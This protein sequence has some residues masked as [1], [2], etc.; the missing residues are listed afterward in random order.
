MKNH[1]NEQYLVNENSGLLKDAIMK[2]EVNRS[3]IVFTI[4][5]NNRLTGVITEG[6]VSRAL[7]GNLTV[8]AS[9]NQFKNVS[10]RFVMSTGNLLTDKRTAMV[11]MAKFD[12]LA[13]PIIDREMQLIELITIKDYFKKTM[14]FVQYG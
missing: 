10:F 9:L 8:D 11:M 7:L 5:N 2:F 4:D 13:V 12:N 1:D 14:D 6:D 3:R